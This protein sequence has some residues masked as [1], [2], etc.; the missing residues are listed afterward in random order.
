MFAHENS[1]SSAIAV[2]IAP[3]SATLSSLETVQFTASVENSPQVSVKW[4]ASGGTISSTGLYQ[5]PE[6]TSD[7][8]VTVTA[9]SVTDP[10]K[11]EVAS[12]TITP[13]GADPTQNPVSNAAT[14]TPKGKE[15][16]Y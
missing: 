12:V 4:V 9:V 2:R 1:S 16:G 8:A 5:A 14:G 3:A 15:V 6:V 10:T 7:T 13:K 11:S